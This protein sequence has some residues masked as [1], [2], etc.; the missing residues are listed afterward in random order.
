MER[1]EEENENKFLFSNERI[2]IL[3]ERRNYL[4]RRNRWKHNEKGRDIPKSWS[5]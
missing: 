2:Y 1:S 3:T 5:L 4:R